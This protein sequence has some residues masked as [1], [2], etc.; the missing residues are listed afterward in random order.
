MKNREWLETLSDEDF[1]KY[2]VRNVLIFS[3]KYRDLT[4]ISYWTNN[5]FFDWL[6]EEHKEEIGNV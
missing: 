1:S 4:T 3:I 5:D 2:V 6:Q